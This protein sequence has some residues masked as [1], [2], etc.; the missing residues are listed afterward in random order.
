MPQNIQ[1]RGHR[2]SANNDAEMTESDLT[3]F[4][5]FY[6]IESKEE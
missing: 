3:N 2:D 4:F 1:L 6:G 5:N